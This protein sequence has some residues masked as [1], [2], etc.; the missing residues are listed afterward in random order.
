MVFKIEFS[1]DDLMSD[2]LDF[3]SSDLQSSCFCFSNLAISSFFKF[4]KNMRGLNVTNN[5][6]IH[7]MIMV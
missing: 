1:Y 7:K 5:E 2:A 4:S 6:F 3:L